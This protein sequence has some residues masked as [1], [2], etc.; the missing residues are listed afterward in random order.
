MD[1][2]IDKL[3]SEMDLRFERLDGKM[4]RIYLMFGLTMTTATIP[5]LQNF[6]GG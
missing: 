4:S 3:S 5:I 2:K 1:S 6:F